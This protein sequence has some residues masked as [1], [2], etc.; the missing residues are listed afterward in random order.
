MAPRV[1][2]SRRLSAAQLEYSRAESAMV[3]R[4]PLHLISDLLRSRLVRSP[5]RSGEKQRSRL[6][7]LFIVKGKETELRQAAGGEAVDR[8]LNARAENDS[9]R[10]DPRHFRIEESTHEA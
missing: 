9:L 7:R 1:H 8:W 10:V 6:I 5:L 4:L 3:D 2:R